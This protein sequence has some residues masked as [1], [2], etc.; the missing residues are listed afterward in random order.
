MKTTFN[1]TTYMLLTYKNI[2]GEYYEKT[3]NDNELKELKLKAFCISLVKLMQLKGFDIKIIENEKSI[4]IFS[5][6]TL[7]VSYDTKL[8]EN[9][10]NENSLKFQLFVEWGFLL[11]MCEKEM[12]LIAL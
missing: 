1:P 6:N 4:D 11:K 3:I 2:M 8:V 5:I 9:I 7:L 12:A 10:K